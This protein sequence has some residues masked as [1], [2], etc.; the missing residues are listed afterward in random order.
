MAPECTVVVPE[1]SA[2]HGPATPHTL[3]RESLLA[4]LT[5]MSELRWLC[6]STVVAQPWFAP[7]GIAVTAVAAAPPVS[8][9]S[10]AT[11]EINAFFI[12][13]PPGSVRRVRPGA[14]GTISPP[15]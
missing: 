1:P 6:T 11:A 8:R 2:F 15:R 14:E 7:A 10:V 13:G 12:L 4:H 5:V 9:V 3:A